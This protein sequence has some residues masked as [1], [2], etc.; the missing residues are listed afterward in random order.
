[1]VVTGG[2]KSKGRGGVPDM[3]AGREGMGGGAAEGC[4]GS[5]EAESNGAGG[6][7]KEGKG[8]ARSRFSWR[9]PVSE[10]HGLA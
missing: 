2:A 7:K 5:G 4:R 6:I 1:M 3:Q 8:G 9:S 10:M